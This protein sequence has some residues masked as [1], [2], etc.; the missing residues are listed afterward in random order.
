MREGKSGTVDVRVR[1]SE[2]VSEGRKEWNSGC[3][4]AREG[5][6]EGKEWM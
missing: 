4:G 2:G 1:E 5:V 3:E 6:R